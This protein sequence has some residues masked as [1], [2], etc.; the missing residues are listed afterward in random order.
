M[1]ISQQII[2]NIKSGNVN[3]K[4]IPLNPINIRDRFRKYIGLVDCL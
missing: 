1:K 4:L 3:V 2:S